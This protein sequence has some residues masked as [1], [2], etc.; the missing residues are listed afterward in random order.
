[1]TDAR[2]PGSAV[3]NPEETV[4]TDGQTPLPTSILEERYRIER[5]IGEGAFGRVYLAMDN[6]L[7]RNVAIKELLASRNT[8]DSETYQRY[9][10]RFQREARATGTI[11][12][13]NVVTVYDLHVDDAGNNYLVME[14]VD[15]TNLRDLLAQ[16]GTLPVN[17]AVAIA[18]DVAKALEA[19]HEQEIVHRDLKP[20]NIMITRRGI[21]KLMDFGIAQ[22]GHESLRTQV[23]SGHPGTPMYMSP[24][25]SSGYGYIDGRS[26]LYS[27]GLVLYEML[28][29][30][31]YVKRRQS[32]GAARPDLPPQLVAVVDRLMHKDAAAR[33]QNANDVVQALTEVGR[34]IGV[35]TRDTPQST[36]T[37]PPSGMVWSQGATASPP[38]IG[39]APP[40]MAPGNR[41]VSTAPS[42]GVP[43]GYGGPPGSLP[44]G[45]PNP[46]NQSAQPPPYGAYP[47]G[48]PTT[49]MGYVGST[50]PISVP[51]PG[52]PPIYGGGA[53]PPIP[54]KKSNR[55][56]IFGII[57][58]VVAVAAIAIIAIIATRP[59]PNPTPTPPRGT[60]VAVNSPTPNS[61]GSPSP[62]PTNTATPAATTAPTTPA[63]P[64]PSPIVS[65]PPSTVVTL[66]T[67]TP[68]ST[69]PRATTPPPATPPRATTP[70][71]TAASG[72][73]FT[74]FTDPKNLVRLQFPTAWKQT[75][76]SSDDTNLIE[77]DG[78]EDV[79]FWLFLNDPQQGSIQEEMDIIKKNQDMSSDFTY[80][81]Q[82]FSD[83]TIS[84]QPAK[85]MTYDF[86]S[87]KDASSKGTG[88][89]WVMNLGGKQWSFK[90]N[91]NGKYQKD[92]D[93]IVNSA[94][95]ASGGSFPFRTW[96]DPKG[97]V[98]VKHPENWK[99]TIDASF[100]GN[101]LELDSP[102]DNYF[103]VDIFENAK[104][105][106]AEVNEYL[107]GHKNSSK[108]TY[109]DGPVSDTK[110][111][112]EPAKTFTFTYAQKDKPG[113][114][115]TGQI[116]VINHGGKEYVLTADNITQQQKANIDA[117]VASLVFL[118]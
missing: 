56:L 69:P 24:E 4:I 83:L 107:T 59:G 70:A 63:T 43:P 38:P 17:R 7:R 71:A 64:V 46:Y 62:A 31:A 16:V 27:L 40:S 57:G 105:L 19:I 1:M 28:V 10:D 84:G 87:M 113:Q 26:D 82:K 12:Q 95:F 103:Y 106:D 76:I 90:S 80:S 114:T 33:Y 53:Q 37:P 45:A 66:S 111:G 41:P 50:A 42:G 29:G 110:I 11:Q 74:T 21:A 73:V 47:S 14:Y 51:P 104:S 98:R 25:Q 94:V 109:T 92:L 75:K 72:G 48:Q 65:T 22:V 99:E 116:W 13:P 8:T 61:G 88:Q 3:P 97:L 9:L 118:Q 39:T 58:G 44:P 117:I 108:L 60:S 20:A 112:G 86:V 34:T 100:D 89:W 93:A 68:S 30:E 49:L 15:G 6:R 52:T 85:T 23:A 35:P 101:F 18:I 79:Y 54:P 32:L 102:D 2:P 5:V 96:T 36:A 81:N 115:E 91:N 78:P 77:L 55:G 67:S